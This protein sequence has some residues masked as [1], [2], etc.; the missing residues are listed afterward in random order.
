[1]T[2]PSR[3]DPR[4][5][6]RPQDSSWQVM[7]WPPPAS[8]TL[9][10]RHV[11]VRPADPEGDAERL[12]RA[13]DDDR[14]WAH[15]RGRPADTRGWTRI[16]HERIEAGW[17][18]W[19]VELNRAYAGLPAGTVVGT[20]SYLE[21]APVDARLEIGGTTYTPQVWGSVVN[22]ETKLLLL[23]Y[24]FEGLHAGRVQL[25]TDVRNHRSQQAIARLGAT[26]E[27]TLRR[28]QRR[29]DDTVRDTVQF[30]IIAEEWPAV[31]QGLQARLQ[32]TLDAG[33][34]DG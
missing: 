7:T 28:Y 15:V 12:F 33:G 29:A 23:A 10:G 21:I 20:S 32:A 5:D 31:R 22:P 2:A 19:V 1:M 24:A 18:P 8:T 26:Y 3:F 16:L 6:P 25:R 11:S 13:L 4:R 17:L 9:S 14:V 27:A 34:L 30:S